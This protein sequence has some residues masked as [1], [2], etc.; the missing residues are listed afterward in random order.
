MADRD[1][2]FADIQIER[3]KPLPC[4]NP[5]SNTEARYRVVFQGA[6]IGV[7]RDP[8]CSAA[9]YLL[10][11]GLAARLDVLRIY[12]GSTLCM[13]GGVG[14]FA[15]RRVDE[16]DT[17]RKDGTPRFG[18]WRPHPFAV[19]RGAGQKPASDDAPATTLPETAGGLP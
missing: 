4:G 3:V 16:S 19:L 7:W 13:S 6:E 18:K 2:P 1:P 17:G 12:R 8:E 9:R 10:D 15:D 5:K 11:H 14:W